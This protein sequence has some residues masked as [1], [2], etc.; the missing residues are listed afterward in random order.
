MEESGQPRP[1]AVSHCGCFSVAGHREKALVNELKKF[2]VENE[3]EVFPARKGFQWEF[4]GLLKQARF[5]FYDV[6]FAPRKYSDRKQRMFYIT[7][8][9]HLLD[10]NLNFIKDLCDGWTYFR[11]FHCYLFDLE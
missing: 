10:F 3:P 2:A 1:F 6:F 9:A 11:I 5:Y 7:C 8:N 4:I